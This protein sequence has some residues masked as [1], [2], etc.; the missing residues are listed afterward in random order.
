[1]DAAL[2]V[3]GAERRAVPGHVR[4]AG[5]ADAD[6]VAL[7]VAPF[8]AA[9]HRAA[10]A[11]ALE[12]GVARELLA[13]L[14]PGV[15]GV[16]EQ[17]LDRA[18]PGQHR[19]E[20]ARHRGRHAARMLSDAGFYAQLERRAD[21]SSSAA[22]IRLVISLA[23]AIYNFT[24]WELGHFEDTDFEIVITDAAAYHDT[25][26]CR[27]VGFI[28]AATS[29]ATGKDWCVTCERTSPARIVF[30]VKHVPA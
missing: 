24:T 13:F 5:R 11:V 3:V 8:G 17:P 16:C 6:V 26:M 25:F 27:N 10:D 18:G 22:L 4:A 15:D 7:E 23:R 20:E 12:V 30:H 2:V 9:G 21:G 1:V 29:L 19:Q 14:H 28:E